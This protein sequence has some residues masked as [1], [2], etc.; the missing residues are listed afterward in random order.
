ML[1]S[2]MSHIEGTFSKYCQ[3]RR[4]LP[5]RGWCLCRQ[6]RCPCSGRSWR[7]RWSAAAAPGQ[8]PRP[9]VD[10]APAR[11]RDRRG[12][13]GPAPSSHLALLKLGEMKR[14]I[15]IIDDR[16]Q[17]LHRQPDCYQLQWWSISFD[18]QISPIFPDS[19]PDLPPRQNWG[20]GGGER[21]VSVSTQPSLLNITVAAVHHHAATTL[22]VDKSLSAAKSKITHSTFPC[23]LSP[24]S[25]SS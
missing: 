6:C 9:R 17:S 19:V 21:L 1:L 4:P 8:R 22:L 10:P 13:R 18:V 5:G 24:G 12:Q 16:Y 14:N 25:Q 2:R 7:S 3:N 11:G 20:G 23:L 15:F